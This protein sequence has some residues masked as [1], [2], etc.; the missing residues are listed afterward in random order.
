MK[1]NDAVSLIVPIK[2][3]KSETGFE[4]TVGEANVIYKYIVTHCQCFPLH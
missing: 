3:P 4:V 1:E 2:N